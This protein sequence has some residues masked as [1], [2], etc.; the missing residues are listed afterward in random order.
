L[1]KRSMDSNTRVHTRQEVMSVLLSNS[2]LL[3]STHNRALTD[4]L[5]MMKP[6]AEKA[7]PLRTSHPCPAESWIRQG[8][9]MTT[10]FVSLDGHATTRPGH[11]LR[12]LKR[13]RL[14]YTERRCRMSALWDALEQATNPCKMHQDAPVFT[15]TRPLPLRGA[16]D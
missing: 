2:A 7:C 13:S 15:Y 14:S 12:C 1:T 8:Q 16:T 5:V 10:S 6:V 3:Q 9:L 11:N 4:F